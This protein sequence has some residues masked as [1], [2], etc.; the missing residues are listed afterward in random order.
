ML[1]LHKWV[2]PISCFI[3]TDRK[4]GNISLKSRKEPVGYCIDCALKNKKLGPKVTIQAFECLECE[5]PERVLVLPE[6]E[7]V[8]RE[9]SGSSYAYSRLLES[10]NAQLPLIEQLSIMFFPKSVSAITKATIRHTSSNHKK[11]NG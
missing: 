8:T 9:I 7:E 11:F 10:K 5:V 4:T 6:Y 2:S 1:L 3:N